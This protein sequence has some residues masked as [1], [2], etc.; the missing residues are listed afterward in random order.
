M[1]RREIAAPRPALHKA[2]ALSSNI[3]ERDLLL[4]RPDQHVAWRG[5]RLPDDPG[6]LLRLVA[7]K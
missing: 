7:G 3:Y 1:P 6:G 4:V 5:D 2:P